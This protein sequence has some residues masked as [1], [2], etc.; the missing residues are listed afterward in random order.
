M[1]SVASVKI[2]NKSN[3]IPEGTLGH[4]G[5]SAATKIAREA[6]SGATI[7]QL[8]PNAKSADAIKAEINVDDLLVALQR[9]AMVSQEDM[10]RGADCAHEMR[11]I[12]RAAVV[13]AIG[14]SNA[15]KCL[16]GLFGIF[17]CTSCTPY[18][19]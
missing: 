2:M 19:D 10:S 3:A 17:K 7:C 12:A 15:K 13:S 5:I 4:E 8:N 9:I 1:G 6:K 18:T 16:L 11:T 14:D